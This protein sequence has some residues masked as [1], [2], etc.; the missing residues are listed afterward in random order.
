MSPSGLPI[1]P[2]GIPPEV[3]YLKLPRV[4]SL[5]AARATRL[6]E[7]AAGHAAPDWLLLLA[8]LCEAQHAA[9]GELHRRG[10]DV[11]EFE[12]TTPLA[13]LDWRARPEWR[14]ALDIILTKVSED[15]GPPLP[16]PA[17]AAIARLRAASDGER[18][19]WAARAIGDVDE[20]EAEAEAAEVAVRPFLA[21]ALQVLFSAQAEHL[22][23]TAIARVE[24][25]CPVCAAPA[26]AGLVMG[27]EKVRYLS[28]S[29]CGSAWH[30]VRV[31]CVT[32]NQPGGVSYYTIDDGSAEGCKA[33]ACSHCHSYLKLFYQEQRPAA[34]PLADDAATI[35]LDLLLGEAGYARGGVNLLVAA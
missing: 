5:F 35:A 25:D 24:A 6:R 16:A 1:V 11:L 33:E 2:G 20:D 18:V 3:P 27:D 19:E 26:V 29:L 34:E 12:R 22:P 21:A 32:C 7:L 9:A 23:A 31:Q 14:S 8:R 4:A 28:C 30:R 10:P 17:Q 15:S 13:A